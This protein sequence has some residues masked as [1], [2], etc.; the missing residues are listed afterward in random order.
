[1]P[2][3]AAAKAALFTTRG[4]A[5]RPKS[6]G[7]HERCCWPIWLGQ[8]GRHAHAQASSEL[9]MEERALWEAAIQLDLVTVSAGDAQVTQGRTVA[10]WMAGQKPATGG[11]CKGHPRR[12]GDRVLLLALGMFNLLVLVALAAAIG[13]VFGYSSREARYP[14]FAGDPPGEHSG[15][16]R[17]LREAGASGRA[18]EIREDKLEGLLAPAPVVSTVAVGRTIMVCSYLLRAFV[19]RVT[20]LMNSHCAEYS[21]GCKGEK[22]CHRHWAQEVRAGR[23]INQSARQYERRQAKARDQNGAERR[24]HQVSHAAPRNA[25]PRPALPFKAT[26][27]LTMQSAARRVR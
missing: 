17:G 8:F 25:P 24:F 1:M 6:S 13:W 21:S 22:Q 9:P 23:P 4:L 18:H 19:V 7:T 11:Q 15:S 10:A 26:P 20:P 16:R 12:A 14:P 27:L 2:S 5:V 3:V